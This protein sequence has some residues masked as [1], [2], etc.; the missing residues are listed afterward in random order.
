MLEG[1]KV[2]YARLVSPSPGLKTLQPRG[3]ETHSAQS[4][5]GE[6]TCS[7]PR[8]R[9]SVLD[10]TWSGLH[11]GAALA[12]ALYPRPYPKAHHDEKDTHGSREGVQLEHGRRPDFRVDR[13]VS[14]DEEVRPAQDLVCWEVN[15]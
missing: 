13:L 14:H 2:S 9:A 5:L 3:S 10:H 6:D 1:D 8:F 4:K 15:G 11:S 7:P 12:S